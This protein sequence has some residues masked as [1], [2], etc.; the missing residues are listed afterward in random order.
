MCIIVAKEKGV[1]MPTK[2]ILR[3]CF[4]NNSDG[5]G[6]M[7]VK[8][9]KVSIRKG[10][11]DFND[12][13]D[14]VQKLDKVHGLKNHAVVMHFRISTQ[15]LVDGGNCHPFPITNNEEIIRKENVNTTLGMAHNG[16]ISDFSDYKSKKGDL[17]D[18]QLFIKE[19]VSVIYRYDK[20]FYKHKDVL[21]MLS[22]IA[23][24]KL[25]FLDTDENITLIGEF[26]KFNGVHYSNTSYSY[27]SLYMGGSYNGYGYGYDLGYG[28]YYDDIIDIDDMVLDKVS[29][30]LPLTRGEFDVLIERLWF[31]SKDSIVEMDNGEVLYIGTDD[32]YA[33]DDYYNLYRV[34]HQDCE[35]SLLGSIDD[36]YDANEK[37]EPYEKLS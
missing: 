15:G 33:I 6:L 1:N 14:Y 3:N 28:D 16:I 12:F 4:N 13:Y 35:I 5:A 25:C 36:F 7:F 22:K 27:K 10:F 19:C 31:L 11:M 2:E 29:G 34:S 30:E 17:N 23:G 26:T 8:D 18:T 9:G 24:S 20:Y 32:K 37:F 21:N